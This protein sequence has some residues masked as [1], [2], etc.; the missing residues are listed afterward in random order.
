[1]QVCVYGGERSTFDVLQ[2]CS[3]LFSETETFTEPVLTK[4]DKM[5]V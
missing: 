3:V 2:S 5:A 4:S 1:M